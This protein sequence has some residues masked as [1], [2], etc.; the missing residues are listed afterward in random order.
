MKRQEEEEAATGEAVASASSHGHDVDVDGESSFVLESA[1]LSEKEI[2]FGFDE[3]LVHPS[4]ARYPKPASA[5]TNLNNESSITNTL[6]APA[7]R[8]NLFAR[9]NNVGTANELSVSRQ[10]S[11]Q[12]DRSAGTSA[13]FSHPPS[14]QV[15]KQTAESTSASASASAA[16]ERVVP[17]IQN[18]RD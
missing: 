11:K 4:S 9:A 13:F 17:H 6:F 10:G 1:V 3:Q 14:K 18:F 12:T 16:R 2:V 15:S 7:S 5:R 8:S